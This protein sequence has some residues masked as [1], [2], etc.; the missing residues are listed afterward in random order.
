[1]GKQQQAQISNYLCF[2]QPKKI[3]EGMAIYIFW[4]GKGKQRLEIVTFLLPTGESAATFLRRS[5]QLS[6]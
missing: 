1:M 6:F 3:N 5:I 4:V 2:Y